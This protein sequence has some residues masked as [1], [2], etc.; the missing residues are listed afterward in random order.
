MRLRTDIF[1]SALLRRVFA[2][3]D[4]AAV[5]RKGAEEAGAI[6]IRQH[7]RDGLET[8]FG[9]APQSVF[10]EETSGDRLFEA[11]LIRQQ[12]DKVR[13]ML[14]RERRFD[15]DLWIIELEADDLGD[16]VPVADERQ[17]PL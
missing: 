9:P 15:P 5:E 1:V 6:F 3:G 16:I 10:S 13:D 7:F 11:R 17:N 14:D 8:V 4:F 2:K 12:P